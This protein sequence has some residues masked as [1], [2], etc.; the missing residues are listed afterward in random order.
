LEDVLINTFISGLQPRIK[1]WVYPPQ[2]FNET[3]ALA[4]RVER[5]DGSAWKIV[6][7]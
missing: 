3:L 2:T 6:T 4:L 7:F 1:E 5:W